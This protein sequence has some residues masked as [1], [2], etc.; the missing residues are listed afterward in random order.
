MIRLL[1]G[2][3]LCATLT[4]SAAFA[5]DKTTISFIHKYPEPESMAFFEKAV[6]AYE[7]ANP[8]IDVVMEA[9]ADDPYKDKIRVLMASDQVPDIFFSWSGEFG[10]KFARDGRTLDLTEALEGEDWEGR[11]SEA[12]LDPLRFEGR[13]FGIPTNVNAKYMVYNASIFEEYGLDEPETFGE[14]ISIL[15][16]L[17]E[18]NVTPIAYGNQVPWAATHYIGDFFAKYVPNDV[19]TADYQL[20]A[21]P[22]EL[23]THPGYIEALQ[24]YADLGEYFN[25][26]ANALPHAA[27]RGS[28]FAGRTAMMYIELVE[29]YMVPGSGL[30]EAGWDFFALP[31]VEGAEGNQNLLTGA[32][33]G[34][35]ISADT[36]VAEE[37]LDFIKFITA[38]NMAKDYVKTTGMTS[39]V[40][41]SVTEE[42]ASEEVIAGLER[43]E[44]ADGMALWLDTDMDTQSANVILAAGQ[45]L[46]SGDVTPEEVMADVRET[47]LEVQ[48][49]R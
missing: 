11:F 2:T 42:T 33:E 27:A 38:P 39:A 19:R 23:Y 36:E 26:G 10:R 4:A 16:T 21:E 3:A 6:A 24:Q 15:D 48:A 7:E 1:T 34:F 29:F 17:K 43:L 12:A 30:E 40:I 46:L 31:P 25:R 18:N 44:R 22:D 13:Q 35:L 5:Q 14:F 45:A 32:P 9:V 28:F 20:L 47:A 37:A 49:T 8:D 41:G